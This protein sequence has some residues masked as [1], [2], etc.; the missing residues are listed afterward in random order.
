MNQS[1]NRLNELSADNA[2]A[3]FMKCCGSKRWAQAM[4]AARPFETIHDLLA[5]A[6]SVW[7][8]LDKEDCLEAFRAHP[9]IGEK[10][11]DSAQS[12]QASNWS[13][14]EQSAVSHATAEVMSALAESNLKYEQRFG[15]I[16]IV[17]ATGKSSEEL[18]KILQSRLRNDPET[19]L[20]NA[21][22]EQ[23]KIIR[24]RLEKLLN[25]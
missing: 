20:R 8:S 14:Q 11:A 24:L 22:E 5:H 17:C 21:T 3:E 6:D 18:L 13:A 7:W 4:T 10:K 2:Q 23:R 16:Y 9:K 12:K 19:E 15:F 25:Q 1:I